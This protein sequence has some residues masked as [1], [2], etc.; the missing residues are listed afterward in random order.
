MT[1]RWVRLQSGISK[2]YLIIDIHRI[3]SKTC[4]KYIDYY[5]AILIS[6]PILARG[7]CISA[8][9]PSFFGISEYPHLRI[10][11]LPLF[12][13]SSCVEQIRRSLIPSPM[14]INYIFVYSGWLDFLLRYIC[15]SV[16]LLERSVDRNPS[17]K[18]IFTS[19]NS[20]MN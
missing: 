6:H 13:I 19:R 18:E 5:M 7:H 14:G 3:L 16:G 2:I 4:D 1:S 10:F 12:E 20:L 9:E 11:F 8:R 15:L 17:S